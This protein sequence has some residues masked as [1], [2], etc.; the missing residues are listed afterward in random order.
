MLAKNKHS[1]NEPNFSGVG[2]DVRSLSMGSGV[3]PTSFSYSP[4]GAGREI[5]GDA[6]VPKSGEP[7]A[8]QVNL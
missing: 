2:D 4:E 1:E 6:G 3:A 7:S 5:P 8:F